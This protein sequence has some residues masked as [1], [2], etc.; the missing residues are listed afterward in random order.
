MADLKA[1]MMKAIKKNEFG[2]M[3]SSDKG[4]DP[5]LASTRVPLLNIA[6]NGQIHGGLESGVTMLVGDSKTFKT[7]YSLEICAAYLKKYDDAFMVFLDS[8]GGASKEYFDTY[9]VDMDRVVHLPIRNIE[10]LKQQTVQLINDLDMDDHVIFFIDS[11][12]MLPSA[13]E[14]ENAMKENEAADMTRAR[15]MNSFWRMVTIEL[16][17]RNLPMI[18]INHYYD[19]IEMF[20]KPVIKGGKNSELSCDNIWLIRKSRIKDGK[21]LN[22]HIFKINMH[23]S[24]RIREGVALPI[25][26]M[27]DG[28]I[29]KYSGLL[30]FGRAAGWIDMPSKGWYSRKKYDEKEDGT[31]AKHRAAHMD[32]DFWEPLLA[33]PEFCRDVEALFKLGADK[34]DDGAELDKLLKEGI[35]P[36]TGEVLDLDDE[37]DDNS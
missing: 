18:C 4:K 12:G 9:G 5:F 33:D 23:K 24:R 30:E 10:D 21:S 6:L 2:S 14:V 22:G 16:K 35:D 8:E 29:Q 17:L 37:D 20:S 15:A 26:V 34:T 36:V 25:E 31:V 32:A 13:K 1:K 19:T 7:C 3:M 28:G 27:F 11:L